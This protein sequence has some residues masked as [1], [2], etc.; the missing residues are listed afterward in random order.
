MARTFRL[1]ALLAPGSIE[2]E[3]GAL[4]QAVFAE[5]GFVSA[6]ALPP[7]VPV[8]FLPVDVPPR[9]P[10]VPGREVAARFAV[11]VAQP[12]WSGDHLFLGIET[13]GAWVALRGDERWSDGPVLFPCFEGFFLGCAEAMPELRGSIVVPPM[14]RRF[15][16]PDITVMTIVVPDEGADWW[17]DV[18]WQID[19]RRPLRGKRSA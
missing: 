1:L 18:S 8:R 15:T 12:A 16:S 9:L 7:L 4:Q 10:Q 3:I 19:D 13:D 11:R 6:I 17:R 5:H 2:A 14:E